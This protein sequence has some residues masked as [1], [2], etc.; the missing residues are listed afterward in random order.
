VNPFHT[1]EFTASEL[2]DLLVGDRFEIVTVFGVHPGERLA[3]LDRM[4]GGSFVDAQL[5][6]PPDEWSDRLRTDVASVRA[7]DFSMRPD[8]G[9]DVDASLDLVI[10]A[11]RPRHSMAAHA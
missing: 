7:D 3:E 8:A 5:A 6:V 1:K 11:S 9:G 10:V 4:H 2:V